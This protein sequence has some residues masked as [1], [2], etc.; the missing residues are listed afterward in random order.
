MTQKQQTDLVANFL[1]PLD[2]RKMIGILGCSQNILK[3][4]ESMVL[5]ENGNCYFMEPSANGIGYDVRLAR[6]TLP[7]DR[8]RI[9]REAYA[10]TSCYPPNFVPELQH[11]YFSYPSAMHT[12]G[13]LQT[14]IPV[15][16]SV[17]LP[18]DHIDQMREVA[19]GK[20]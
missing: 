7:C 15:K 12:A 13:D 3:Q 18:A 14:I 16:I 19:A 2:A 17:E 9:E 4:D 20:A 8:I 10:I 6:G 5:F 11:I 1:N